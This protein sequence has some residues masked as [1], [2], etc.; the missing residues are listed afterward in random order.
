MDPNSRNTGVPNQKN[1]S[2]PFYPSKSLVSKFPQ[3]VPNSS[4]S[5]QIEEFPPG[6]Q[7]PSFLGHFHYLQG[8][9][10]HKIPTSHPQHSRFDSSSKNLRHDDEL[11]S[12]NQS[13]NFES[14]K[15]HMGMRYKQ[16]PESSDLS[17]LSR[18]SF[19][20]KPQDRFVPF[21]QDT[22]SN[23]SFS[24][25]E[26]GFR[27]VSSSYLNPGFMGSFSTEPSSHISQ[28]P[29]FQNVRDTSH[30]RN[31]ESLFTN[32]E[33][34]PSPIEESKS[35]SNPAEDIMN[36]IAQ[37]QINCVSLL[38]EVGSKV[39]KRVDYVIKEVPVGKIKM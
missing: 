16:D 15:T 29:V 10:Q 39:K 11:R 17:F 6:I 25:N 3:N 26:T 13:L 34:K 33:T 4:E 1:T 22:S 27:D 8:D 21:P 19:A 5:Q 37:N 9:S 2:Q 7:P 24:S 18:Q 12:A 28:Q 30:F 38:N 14:S 36:A 35:S 23:L 20:Q 32:Q 31:D